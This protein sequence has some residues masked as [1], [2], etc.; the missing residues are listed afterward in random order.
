VFTSQEQA[1]A[2]LKTGRLV[3]GTVA[4][5]AGM[6]CRGGPGM[7]LASGFVAAVDG[8]G[9]STTVAVITDGQLSGLNR[10]SAIGQVAPEA[11]R[12]AGPRARRRRHHD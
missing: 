8:A 1:L 12:P 9:L 5:L 7:A 10:G 6:G 11:R 3:R 4:V 2:A